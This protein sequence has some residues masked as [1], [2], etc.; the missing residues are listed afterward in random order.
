M[1]V[2]GVF[3]A[4]PACTRFTATPAPVSATDI[5]ARA[6]ESL[7]LAIGRL[8]RRQFTAA[9]EAVGR[10]LAGA[11]PQTVTI[12]G[13]SFGVVRF[14]EDSPFIPAF[15]HH[16]LTT[17]TPGA[18]ASLGLTPHAM[19]AVGSARL[20]ALAMMRRYRMDSPH[21]CAGSFGY[22]M[23]GLRR[24][25][26]LAPLLAPLSRRI[27]TGPVYHGC[28]MADY[29]QWWMPAEFWLW[30]DTD[31][32][33]VIMAAWTSEHH[34]Q[35]G[36]VA[37]PPAFSHHFSRHRDVTPTAGRFPAWL[38]PR[39][40][41]FLTWIV[42][43]A[44]P[45]TAPLAE[46]DPFVNANILFALGISNN[47][48]TPGVE[49]AIRLVNDA[50]ARGLHEHPRHASLYYIDNFLPHYV[51]TRAWREGNV[52]GLRP[53]V[54]RVVRHVEQCARRRPD[55]A[56]VWNHGHPQLDTA[57]AI[58]SLLDGGGAPDLVDGGIRS[59]IDMQNPHTGGWDAAPLFGGTTDNG[60]RLIWQSP[61]GTT[62]FAAEALARYLRRASARATGRPHAAAPL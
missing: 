51:I 34:L 60:A 54:S 40:G 1:L 7:Q 18:A 31:D 49:Q 33:A 55:G 19:D 57:L 16:S 50:T 58:L 14:R 6:R 20:R 41:A 4:P 46:V 23:P 11:W 36:A 28:L 52:S 32:S 45:V 27:M 48:G 62:A 21:D 8:A 53:S 39:S 9:D 59:L 5:D 13:P 30:P 25:R 22:W 56:V 61:D 43:A 35:P 15:I 42:P 44:T 26:A 17:I 47:L 38:A 3:L 2:C 24:S 29:T 10:G 37:P 12:H